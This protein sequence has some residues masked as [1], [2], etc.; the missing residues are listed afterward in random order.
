MSDS[1]LALLTFNIGNPSPARAE[2]QLAWLAGRDEHVIVLTETKAS[3]GC[4][5]L[6]DAFSA[7]GHTITYRNQSPASTES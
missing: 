3:T 4:Q 5:L 1:G 7:A 2:R 6:A